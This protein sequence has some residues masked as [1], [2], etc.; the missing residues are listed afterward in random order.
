M[1][2][3]VVLLDATATDSQ[4][5]SFKQFIDNTHLGYWHWL[6]RA[7]LLCKVDDNSEFSADTIRDKVGECYPGV[8]CLVLELNK[9]GDTWAGFGPNGDK[10]NMFAWLKKNWSSKKSR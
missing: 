5:K 7:W 1:K 6:A 2:R 3:F 8:R 4:H 9:D 10:N